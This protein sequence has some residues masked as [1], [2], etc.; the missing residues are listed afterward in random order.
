MGVAGAG[1]TTIGEQLAVQL[2]WTYYDADDFHPRVNVAKIRDGTPLTDED[3]APWLARL[4]EVAKSASDA[5]RSII[6]GCSALKARYREQFA[7]GVEG[8]RFVHLKGPQA[9]IAKRLAT[10]RGHFMPPGLLDSQFAALEEPADAIVVS[11]A[12]TPDEM[13][14]EIVGAIGRS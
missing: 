2:G 11:I 4:N 7:A 1:K 12:Q 13:V 9:L 10:R 3:R 8:M 5:G 6:I 14:E